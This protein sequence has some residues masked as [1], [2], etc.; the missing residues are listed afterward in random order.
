MPVYLYQYVALFYYTLG[1][2]RPKL[3]ATLKTIQLIATVTYPNLKE[4][5][6]EPILKPFIDDVNELSEVCICKFEHNIILYLTLFT[7]TDGILSSCKWTSFV[8]EGSGTSIT[9]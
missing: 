3:R 4:Y 7:L 8:C 9:S 5:G 1:N 2:I 6:F